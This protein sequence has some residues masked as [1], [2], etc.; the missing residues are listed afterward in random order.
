[1]SE[2][3]SRKQFHEY[4]SYLK[5]LDSG[6]SQ[7]QFC[8]LDAKSPQT[9]KITKYF[10]IARNIFPYSVWDS[11]QVDDHLLLI[12]KEHTDTLADLSKDAAAEFVK[13]ISDYE[14]SGYNIYARAPG[15]KMKSIIHQHT[16]L[17]KAKP[18]MISGLLYNRKPYIRWVKK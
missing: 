8:E 1:M 2:T 6:A 14:S 18:G 5:S 9:I 12:P 11:H 13:I 10:K 15:S 17:I 16:H 3:R 4:N 7:C